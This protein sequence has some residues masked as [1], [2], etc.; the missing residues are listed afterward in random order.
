MK[1]FEELIDRIKGILRT[2]NNGEHSF[3][4]QSGGC[5]DCSALPEVVSLDGYIGSVEKIY[6]S[7]NGKVVANGRTEWDDFNLYLDDYLSY[8]EVSDILTT[9]EEQLGMEVSP[10]FKKDTFHITSVCRDDITA[11]GYKGAENI[12]DSVMEKIAQKMRDA[13]VANS[14]WSDLDFFVG[15]YCDL[16]KEED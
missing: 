16:E 13:Y 11:L 4:I 7:E 5:T 15:E 1:N 10:T 14:F 6:I 3:V 8:D 2:C 9:M 12:S